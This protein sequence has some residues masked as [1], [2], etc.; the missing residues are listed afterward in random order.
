MRI[1]SNYPS[2]LIS[3]TTCT[4]HL[5][6]EGR[7][8]S[9]D[10]RPGRALVRGH[11]RGRWSA[12]VGLLWRWGRCAVGG[13][14]ARVVWRLCGCRRC[15]ARESHTARQMGCSTKQPRE[16]GQKEQQ[17]KWETQKRSCQVGLVKSTS[18]DS[19]S[20][21]LICITDSKIVSHRA[22]MLVSG[23]PVA[24][25]SPG[26]VVCGG[27]ACSCFSACIKWKFKARID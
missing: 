6:Y 12:V 3:L 2:V 5:F 10:D 9:S 24:G 20:I 1:Q 17:N 23:A 8:C 21:R 27:A 7:R 14:R 11:G 26:R 22:S 15:T 13:R 4:L 25:C 19:D 16:I 18:G